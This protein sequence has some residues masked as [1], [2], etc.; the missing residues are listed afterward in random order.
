LKEDRKRAGDRG[1]EAAANFLQNTGY[2][3]LKRNYRQRF[4]EIDIIAFRDGVLVFCEVKSSRYAGES[5]PE[6]RVDWKKQIKLSRIAR[7][8]ISETQFSFESCR[9]DVIAV[10]T[11][12]GRE[13]I[14]HIENAFWPPEGWEEG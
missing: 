3:I 5:H 10:K 1:E 13:V 4:G 11:V 12:R 6:L 14:E 7:A 9:F 8:F 2:T